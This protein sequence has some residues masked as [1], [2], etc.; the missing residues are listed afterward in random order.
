MAFTTPLYPGIDLDADQGP[1]MNNVAAAFIALS[2]AVLTLRFISRVVTHV[3]IGMDDWL[4]VAAAVGPRRSA[5]FSMLWTLIQVCLGPFMGI[6]C[7]GD[8]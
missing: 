7:D 3:D 6:H 1:Q 8:R 5:I 2:F 4:I